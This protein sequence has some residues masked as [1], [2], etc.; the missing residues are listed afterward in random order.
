VLNDIVANATWIRFKLCLSEE[1][2]GPRK[3]IESN[4]WQNYLCSADLLSKW[5]FGTLTEKIA[6]KYLYYSTL[7][8]YRNTE[9]HCLYQLPMSVFSS[10]WK[11]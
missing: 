2:S 6:A 8:K 10:D 5:G 3:A 7:Q 9:L 11:M 4:I 1:G